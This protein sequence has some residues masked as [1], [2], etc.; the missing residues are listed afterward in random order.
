MRNLVSQHS[1]DRDD[2]WRQLRYVPN[3]A[4][5]QK[6]HWQLSAR[7]R[8]AVDGKC[9]VALNNRGIGVFIAFHECE[10]LNTWNQ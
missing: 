8:G 6:V 3:P 2:Q 4:L 9:N 5:V 1:G 10:K 7:Y